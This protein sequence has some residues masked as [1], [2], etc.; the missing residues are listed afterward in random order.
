MPSHYPTTPEYAKGNTGTDEVLTTPYVE[1]NRGGPTDEYE[2]ITFQRKCSGFS[3]EELRLA[4]YQQGRGGARANR[5]AQTPTSDHGAPLATV[6]L[7]PERRDKRSLRLCVN[8]FFSNSTL[9]AN[10]L[11]GSAVLAS[12]Y[13]LAQHLVYAQIQPRANV[14]FPGLYPRL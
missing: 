10:L 13:A 1:D 4:D 14:K 6:I 11:T 8:A 3:L 2:T 5:L 7:P 9:M 12:K